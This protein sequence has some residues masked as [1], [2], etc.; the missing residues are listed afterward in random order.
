M[1]FPFSSIED[2]RVEL[3]SEHELFRKTVR[4][5]AE[6][7][8]EPHLREI[9]RTNQ[10]PQQLLKKA[11]ELG[12]F[13]L[14]IPEE[15]GG[16]GTDL[17]YNSIYV[18]EVSRICPAFT[19][20]TLVH[21]L[22]TFPVLKFGTEEQRRKYLTLLAR[23]EKH[24]AHATTEPGAGSDVAAIETTAK[25]K[26][27][28]WVINGR[29]YF[30]SGADKAD[31]FLVL[32]RTS[33]PPS[34]KE[35][36]K[37]LTFFIVERGTEGFR[38][39]EKIEVIGIRGSHPCEVILDNVYVPDENRVGEE[40]MGFKI[41]METYDHGR[42]G[43][44]AQAVGV[45]QAAFEKSLQYTMQRRAFERP[46][47]GFQAVQFHI[48]EMLTYLEAARLMLYWA[49]HL[50]TRERPEAVFAASMAKLFA[51]EAAEKAAL[52]AITVHGGMGVAVEGMVE[53]F[54]R[55]VQIFKT[56][57]GTNDIQR[58]V[59]MRQ[60]MKQAFGMEIS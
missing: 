28:G 50:A 10:I 59:I 18:E 33:P 31:Y 26:N 2:F 6:R 60:M 17:I 24:A 11:A 48:S 16:Q 22:F 32:A 3:K 39:G 58:L 29:K 43:V 47:L 25:E 42:L 30:I 53:R 57:E 19:V 15:Y 5:F 1:V 23:G 36:W 52:K 51:T 27:G 56:Y 49:S 41:A 13:G 37:G 54:L 4:E 46:L 12:Y 35:R 14:G 44:A 7:E 34:K 21:S 9:E 38:V 40:G 45:A 20:A 55:D 8:L